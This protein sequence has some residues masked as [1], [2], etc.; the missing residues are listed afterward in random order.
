M[1]KDILDGKWHADGYERGAYWAR[2]WNDIEQK[3]EI[4]GFEVRITNREDPIMILSEEE[5]A[6][7]C[8]QVKSKRAKWMREQNKGV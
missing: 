1:S 3:F 4:H 5:F 2:R 7:E 6:E 8:K